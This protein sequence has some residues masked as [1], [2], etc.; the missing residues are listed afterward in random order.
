MPYLLI[1][2]KW[3]SKTFRI[4]ACIM[5][6]AK[7]LS[8]WISHD[9]F[10]KHKSAIWKLKKVLLLQFR[11]GFRGFWSNN[12]RWKT[13]LAPCSKFFASFIHSK[14]VNFIILVNWCD[15]PIIDLRDWIIENWT[16]FK[17]FGFWNF[18]NLIINMLKP[19][20][21]FKII[22]FPNKYKSRDSE[23]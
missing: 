9:S 15:Y 22:T 10:R 17:P 7:R 16:S 23:N 12:Y 6:S 4:L 14:K 21:S 1:Y 5:F 13:F 11:D 19:D 3:R 2:I 20:S 8:F 18:F